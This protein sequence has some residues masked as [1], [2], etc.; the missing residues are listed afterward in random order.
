MA[1]E[2]LLI[3]KGTT[4]PLRFITRNCPGAVAVMLALTGDSSFTG[5]L[6][7]VPDVLLSI[8]I[9]APMSWRKALLL[10]GYHWLLLIVFKLLHTPLLRPMIDPVGSPDSQSPGGLP[11]REG[12][13]F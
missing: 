5:V 7:A 11:L 6:V 2:I 13:P 9:F 4:V 10:Y 1:T 3:S 8:C 12:P